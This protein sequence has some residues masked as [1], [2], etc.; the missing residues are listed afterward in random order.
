MQ[1]I[2]INKIC[3][4]K[5]KKERNDTAAE[6]TFGMG[7]FR[8]SSAGDVKSALAV[9]TGDNMFFKVDSI[10]NIF[11]VGIAISISIHVFVCH[12]F[13]ICKNDKSQDTHGR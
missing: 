10:I 9:A 6:Q 1:I 4:K 2:I 3:K 8:T 13:S 11:V 7:A 12:F 5:T